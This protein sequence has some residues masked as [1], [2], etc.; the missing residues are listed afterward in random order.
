MRAKLLF[1]IALPLMVGCTDQNSTFFEEVERETPVDVTRL[2]IDAFGNLYPNS[3]LNPKYE[4]M[5][6][7]QGSLLNAMKDSSSGLCEQDMKFSDAR[8]LCDSLPTGDWHNGQTTLW[9]KAANSIVQKAAAEGGD[10][11]LVFL[12][13]GFNN[14][15]KEARASFTEARKVIVDYKAPN[16]RQHFV[17]IYWDGFKSDTTKV[18]AWRKAQAAGPLVG[19]KLRRLMHELKKELGNSEAAPVRVRFLTHSSGAFVVGSLFGDP[20][21]ALPLL[22]K[23]QGSDYKYFAQYRNNTDATNQ[24]SIA[25]FKDLRVGM[26]APATSDWTFVGNKKYEAGFRS[27]GATVLFSIQPNDEA[28]TKVFLGPDFPSSGSTGLGVDKTNHYCGELRT[29]SD[30]ASRN[31]KFI[32]YDFSR[33]EKQFPG[34]EK[35]HDFTVYLEQATARSSFMKDLF[36]SEPIDL[37][38][39][40]NRICGKG[41]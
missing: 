22:Q 15:A 20:I 29:N 8:I 7:H 17:E 3:G 24:N 18:D 23:G 27:S 37:D 39:K 25:S 14:L 26:L 6:N 33:N 16:R 12:V 38:A 1:I 35:A 34:K 9:A 4:M 30:L 2:Y 32:G 10:L 31:I 5:P 41:N 40:E 13:H 11:D 19:F 21:A 36:S 28:L